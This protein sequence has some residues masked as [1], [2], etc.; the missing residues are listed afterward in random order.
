MTWWILVL[1]AWAGANLAFLA[2]ALCR[3]FRG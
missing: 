1:V 2:I 3:W